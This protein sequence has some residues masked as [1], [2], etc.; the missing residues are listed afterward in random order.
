VRD[1][2]IA[3]GLLLIAMGAALVFG[4][5]LARHLPAVGELHPLLFVSVKVGD[6]TV[7]TSP[8]L[9]VVLLAL[10]LILMRW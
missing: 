7:G 4:S 10:Y 3:L 9:I 8:L 1:P 5:L 2:L 6:V